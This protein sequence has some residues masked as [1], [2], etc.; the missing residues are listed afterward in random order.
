M[1]DDLLEMFQ[2]PEGQDL[3]ILWLDR[4]G[5]FVKTDS[6]TN[7][8]R[9]SLFG[10]KPKSEEI[11]GFILVTYSEFMDLCLEQESNLP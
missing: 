8:D 4:R 1:K 3:C 9:P 2:L 7:L 10:I 11:R 6:L 5:D